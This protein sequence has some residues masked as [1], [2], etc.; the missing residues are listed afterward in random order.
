MSFCPLE[1]SAVWVTVWV[2]RGF[3]YIPKLLS[4]Y[5]IPKTNKKSGNILISGLFMVA[6]AGLEPTTSGL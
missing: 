4:N 6:E 5:L 2:K 3:P 1:T